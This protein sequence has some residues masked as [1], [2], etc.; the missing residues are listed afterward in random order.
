MLATSV[1]FLTMISG[2]L[3]VGTA[4]N[5]SEVRFHVSKFVDLVELHFAHDEILEAG[6]VR[7][8]FSVRSLGSVVVDA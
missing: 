5:L 2:G 7:V 4:K 8:M 1:H 3:L 6:A